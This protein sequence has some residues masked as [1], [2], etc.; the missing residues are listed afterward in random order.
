MLAF[1]FTPIAYWSVI[2]ITGFFIFVFDEKLFRKIIDIL[3]QPEDY[4][5]IGAELGANKESD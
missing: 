2:I 4:A 5:K 1:G 3:P